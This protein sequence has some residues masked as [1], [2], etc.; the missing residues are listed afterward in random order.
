MTNKNFEIK[1]FIAVKLKKT[2]NRFFNKILYPIEKYEINNPLI[3]LKHLK[4][5]LNIPLYQ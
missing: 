1:K 2:L 3:E 4:I 5:R